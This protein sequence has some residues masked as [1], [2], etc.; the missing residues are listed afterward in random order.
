VLYLENNLTPR[1]FTPNRITVLKLL[2]S[3]AAISLENTRLYAD[4]EKSESYLTQAQTLSRTGSFGW[5]VSAG[6]ILWSDETY[7]IMG[8]ARG[9]KPTLD[10]VFDR[11]HPDDREQVK[12]ILGRAAQDGREL[13]FEHRLLMPDGS[14]KN[15]H[16]VAQAARNDSNDFE[17]IGAATDITD[18][19]RTENELQ[20]AFDEIK[21]LKDQLFEENIALRQEIDQASLFEEIVGSSK[22]LR[23]TLAQVAKVAPTDS[24]VLITGETGT[25]KELV[26][27]AIHKRSHRSARAFVGVN[28][29]GIPRDLIAS[30]LFG[31]EK[32]AFTGATQQR[33]GRFELAG[34]GTLFL[35]EV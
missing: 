20:K 21:K 14:T 10:L 3:Q 28:C 31:H 29:A 4:L 32:G 26:A 24:T 8:H 34:G 19:K 13:D 25:G 23:N 22:A 15:I 17:Y 9:M 33:L 2:A 7:R 16:V 12:E 27:R 6:Q 11:I 1:A 35:D 5:N 30:E 18:R